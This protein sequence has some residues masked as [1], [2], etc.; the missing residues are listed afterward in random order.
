MYDDALKELLAIGL[1]SPEDEVLEVL[2]REAIVASQLLY[3]SIAFAVNDRFDF[4]RIPV[5]CHTDTLIPKR[6]ATE[7]RNL[8]LL[9]IIRLIRPLSD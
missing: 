7:S 5:I 2:L 4:T 1:T 6:C 8:Y 9:A 3:I